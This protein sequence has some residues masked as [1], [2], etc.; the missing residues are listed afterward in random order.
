MIEKI[1]IEEHRFMNIFFLSLLDFSNLCDRNIYTDLLNEFL[2]NGHCIYVISPIEKRRNVNTY[3]FK[4]N[5]LTILK[6]RIGNTQKVNL[7]EKGIS[8]LTLESKLVAGI[9]K[10]FSDVKFDLILYTTPPVTFYRAVNYLKQRDSAKTYLLLKDIFPQNAV[11]LG[12]LSKKGVKGLIYKYFRRKEK[13]LYNISD[14]IGCLSSANKD[15]LLKHNEELSNKPI[16]V[17]PNSITPIKL[18][19]HDKNLIKKKFDIPVD[20]VSF[21]YGGN[22]GKPQDINFVII[23]LKRNLNRM[24]RY[25]VICGTGTDYYK[26]EAFFDKERPKNMKLIKGLPKQEYDELVLACDIGLIF[27]D[28]RF[29]IP[30]FPCRLL[31]YLENVMPVLACT[32]INTDVGRIIEDGEFGWWC[33]SNDEKKFN[34]IV[35]DICENRNMILPMGINARNYLERNYTVDKSYKAIMNHFTDINNH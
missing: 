7:V 24:D 20:C 13:N 29:T 30:N 9:K 28:H 35:D 27:L 32:D 22:L 10:F 8:T 18:V 17:C 5:C 19:Q 3:L 11:D 4:E 33:E 15:F 21:I 14:Y 31:T 34:D 25:F 6:V 2:K 16:E 1:E 23:C 12:I 26:L